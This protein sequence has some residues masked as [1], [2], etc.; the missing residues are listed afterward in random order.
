[1][2]TIK[3]KC[4]GCGESRACDEDHGGR[5]EDCP[6]CGAPS[7]LPLKIT[8]P[9]CDG[10]YL[11]FEQHFGHAIPCPKCSSIIS[12]PDLRQSAPPR[13]H[14]SRPAMPPPRSGSP[15]HE[16][17]APARALADEPSSASPINPTPVSATVNEEGPG[18]ALD[19]APT[20]DSESA[21]ASAHESAVPDDGTPAPEGEE[22]AKPG[23]SGNAPKPTY[24][25]DK[26]PRR[27]VPSPEELEGRYRGLLSNVPKTSNG[28]YGFGQVTIG[29]TKEGMHVALREFR[30]KSPKVSKL[31]AG[32]Y[33]EFTVDPG[34]EKTKGNVE[35]KDIELLAEDIDREDTDGL[36]SG[37][38]V[39]LT[40]D[41]GHCDIASRIQK[42]PVFSFLTAFSERGA[43]EVQ[44]H[45]SVRFRTTK[46]K[47]GIRATGVACLAPAQLSF[48]TITSY[49]RSRKEGRIAAVNGTVE[50][51]FVREGVKSPRHIGDIHWLRYGESVSFFM[52]DDE[53]VDIGRATPLELF[54]DLGDEEHVIEKLKSMVLSGEEWS[55]R[56][57]T[58]RRKNPILRN[59]LFFTFSRLRDE[60]EDPD[61]NDIK[62]SIRETDTGRNLAVFDT[63]LVNETY[64]SI[65]ACFVQNGDSVAGKP[66]W[67]FETFA[68]R[69]D[70][71]GKRYLTF[72]P[73][74]KRATY[75]TDP[76]VLIYDSNRR[77]DHTIN[78]ILED[79]RKR[80]PV[81][82]RD[83]V[84]STMSQAQAKA[85]L[86]SYLKDAIERA[87]DRCTWNY[88]TAIPQWYNGR[89]Q[90]LLPL[91]MADPRTVD[92]ALVVERKDDIY[93]GN[94][95]LELDWAY[96][97]ARLITRPD[98]DWLRPSA[99]DETSQD[100]RDPDDDVE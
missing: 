39:G 49:N 1:M 75:F 48:G 52:V 34:A 24:R 76:S 95:I 42:A 31:Y 16:P 86:N 6:H 22:A 51:R 92:V 63:G 3:F 64:N 84:P 27:R 10:S 4:Q 78:H 35:A 45:S 25:R 32:D 93:V 13:P 54:A 41:R 30:K 33:I 85:F 57:S 70:R 53:A 65:Y 56:T 23:R 72:D 66:R 60:Q 59:Y 46:T 26:P 99:I 2:P 29:G 68:T 91:C 19:A 62:I 37:V 100:D 71:M 5:S 73:L 14:T 96:M 61:T 43:D 77:L 89:I 67:R 28:K 40:K 8:C 55:F 83:S 11:A 38:I 69:G 21:A 7:I 50:Y 9:E 79:R 47:N 97:N 87:G 98:T 44:L 20:A 74:P 80:L 15:N 90:L 82:I 12:I 94:T 17:P 18:T 88:K 58:E 81:V 36:H